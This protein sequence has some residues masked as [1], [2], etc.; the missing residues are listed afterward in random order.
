ME[1]YQ[2]NTSTSMEH[3]S[4]PASLTVE[5]VVAIVEARVEGRF[6]LLTDMLSRHIGITF[7][8]QKRTDE[9][10]NELI[11]LIADLYEDPQT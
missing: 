11:D 3:K 10:L 4:S 6:N 1:R 2:N 5:K 8:D 9:K 7:R